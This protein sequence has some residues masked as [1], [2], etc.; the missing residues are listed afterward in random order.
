MPDTNISVV[1]SCPAKQSVWFR[2]KERQRHQ[3]NLKHILNTAQDVWFWWCFLDFF[4]FFDWNMVLMNIE[5]KSS[6]VK[7]G[8][9]T[10]S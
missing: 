10:L 1:S 2:H 3:L 6:K 9:K 4:F 5:L 7:K 8:E